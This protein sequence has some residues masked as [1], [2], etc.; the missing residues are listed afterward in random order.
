MTNED[1]ARISRNPVLT[2]TGH[3]A[4]MQMAFYTGDMFPAEYRNDAFIAMR[5]SWNRK[6][7][8]GY[9]VVRIR[10]DR[11]GRA[12]SIEP[13]LSGFL[14]KGGAPNGGDGN[15]ARLAGVAVMKDG[16]LLITDDTNNTIYRVS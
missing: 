4:P 12:T 13:F 11:A 9:E 15:F 7:P 3:S 14:V 1:W 5:G 16:S 10:F 8:S 6:P 2:Y